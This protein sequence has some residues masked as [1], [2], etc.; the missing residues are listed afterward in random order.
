MDTRINLK[1]LLVQYTRHMTS[2]P[3]IVYV[4]LGGPIPRYGIRNLK[5]FIEKFPKLE[6]I[7]ISDNPSN[8]LFD[9]VKF[10]FFDYAAV[11][12]D[13]SLK[14]AHDKN[15]RGGFWIHTLARFE[16]LNDWT[17]KNPGQS[18]IHFEF[19]VWIAENFP[20]DLFAQFKTEI[21]YTLPSE[22]E[23]SAAILYLPNENVS[24]N[25]ISVTREL[26]Q[27]NPKSTDMSILRNIYDRQL[28][29]V[30][31]LP[32]SPKDI[33]R[34]S[35]GKINFIF[36]PSSWGMFYLGQ[37]PRNSRGIQRFRVQEPH[38]LIKPE[39]YLLQ[40]NGKTISVFDEGSRYELVNLHVHS[41][42]LRL[43]KNNQSAQ[44]HLIRYLNYGKAAQ[45]SE[46]KL[47]IFASLATRKISR[48]IRKVWRGI[49]AIND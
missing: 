11:W 37:D 40:T 32:C 1:D 38:H 19:D 33:H 5:M 15:F 7:L 12:A 24:S 46:F 18:I 9:E 4:Y 41:K 23:G 3:K 13:L 8:D 26:I 47:G 25:F 10:H 28:I 36:D 30:S 43:F 27:K 22:S 29:N 48:D 49:R 35:N 6:I 44:K 17:Q 45:Y 20:F 39:D 2:T 31:I 16:A 34:F 14:G 21:A 42:D